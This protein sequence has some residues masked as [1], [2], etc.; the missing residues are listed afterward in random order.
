MFL[1]L[2]SS[3][4]KIVKKNLFS[5]ETFKISPENKCNTGTNQGIFHHAGVHKFIVPVENTKNS[6]ASFFVNLMMM[7]RC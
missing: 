1:N 2:H 5:F 4:V 7:S 6:F 3:S